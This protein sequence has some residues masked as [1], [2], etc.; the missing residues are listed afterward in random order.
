VAGLAILGVSIFALVDSHSASAVL[1][2]SASVMSGG[3]ADIS[4]NNIY[5][6]SVLRDFFTRANP[7]IASYNASVV[8]FYNATGSLTRFENKK[9]IL[10]LKTV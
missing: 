2:N 9:Y 7:T 4:L 10:L 3:N 6:W 1:A 8:N 5:Y